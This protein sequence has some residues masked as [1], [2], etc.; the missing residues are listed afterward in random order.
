MCRDP[1]H[2]KYDNA[3]Y[4]RYISQIINVG[5]VH[6]L[7]VQQMACDSEIHTQIW[8]DIHTVVAHGRGKRLYDTKQRQ[9]VIARDRGCQAPACTI[10]AALC[11]VHHKVPWSQGGTTDIDN[12]ILL[13]TYHHAQVH[14]EKWKIITRN[15]V[16]YFQPARWI[17]P[18]QP[19]LR[20]TTWAL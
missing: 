15:G 9:A 18:L 17:D 10:P 12:A 20:N 3:K 2:A 4:T 19:L 16:T 13:C 5:P 7:Y 1:E 6:P 14:N 8:D 11:D